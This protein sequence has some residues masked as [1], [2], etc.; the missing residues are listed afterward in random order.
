MV[1][2]LIG[3]GIAVDDDVYFLPFDSN[4]RARSTESLHL[5]QVLKELLRDSSN[6][7]GLIVLL[8]TCYAGIG[9]SE[10]ARW[11]EVGL[12]RHLRRYEIL[13]ASS[14]Q[15]AYNGNFTRTLI[16]VLTTGIRAAG[17]TIDA[18]YLRA[19]LM[20]RCGAQRPQ[21]VTHD[22]GGWAQAGDEGLW[23]A[24]N[25]AYLTGDSAISRAVIDRAAELTAYLEPTPIL[26]K[27]V[28]ASDSHQC[29]I[30]SGPRG[31]GKST[32]AAALSRP[33]ET[34]GM[35][36]AHFVQGVAFANRTSILTDIAATLAG[37]LEDSVPNFREAV[38]AYQRRLS[39][40]EAESLD[41]F[42]R[43]LVGP[44]QYLAPGTP[45]RI[46][47]DALDELPAATAEAMRAALN[48]ASALGLRVILTARPTVSGLPGS[49]RVSIESA[50]PD[51]MRSYFVKR[52][53]AA[54]HI[55][56]LVKRADGSW[57]HAYLMSDQALA[58]GFSLQDLPTGIRAPITALYE[59]ELVRGGAGDRK[60]WESDLRPVAGLLAVAGHGPQLPL[61]LATAASAKLGGPGTPTAFRDVLVRLSGLVVRDQPGQPTER[62]GFFHAS[63]ADD[64]F[65]SPDE[66]GQFPIDASLYHQALAD[67]IDQLAPLGS[68]DPA[69]SLHQYALMAEPDHRW[70]GQCDSGGVLASLAG[71]PVERAADQRERYQRWAGVLER[72]NGPEHL[73]TLAVKAD[74]ARWT[75]VAG[76]AVTARDTL[77]ELLP[78]RERVSGAH[79]PETLAVRADHARWTGLAGDPVGARELFARLLPVM[80]DVFGPDHPETLT[81]RANIARWTGLAGAVASARD[82]FSV[83]LPIRE[84]V[85]GKEHPETLTVRANT[86]RWTGLAGDP[87]AARDFFASLLPVRRRVSGPEHRHTLSDRAEFA[88]WTGEAGNAAAARDL[89]AE[90]L[91]AYER[92]NGPE[93]PHTLAVKADLARWTGV[94]DDDAVTARD[95]LSELLPARERMSGAH[96][97]ETLAVRA[98]H[99]RWTGLAGD[100]VGA[101]ELFARLLPVMEDV[102]G[103]D[104]PETLT[105]RANIARWT[106]LAGD[107]V[108]A[109]DFFASLLPVRRRVSGPEH[110]HT[111]SDRA[112]FA[113]WTGEA[114]NA[115]AARDLLAELLPAYER[116]NGPEHPHTLAVKADLARWTGVADDDAVTARDMLSELLPARERVSGAHHPETLAVRADHARWAVRVKPAES[117]RGKHSPSGEAG[118]D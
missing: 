15:P 89:L 17:T 75:G 92:A 53:V 96:H 81:V 74:L 50:K 24:R 39:R 44:L 29:V 99:A 71:R 85:S 54:A 31:S 51:V 86:A 108:A 68:H 30:V 87:V 115:A 103:P 7:D 19:P 116:A 110:R 98:D 49:C 37:Q 94:A 28:A 55:D 101:R 40:A 34:D 45:V 27:I 66:S 35:V 52:G 102:F 18:R 48:S 8:D 83:L 2:A 63:V 25:A 22:G 23:L 36:P 91:P 84:R 73:H 90:L 76:D 64:Y 33:T 65:L 97:P 13:T 112:E 5:S 106:G 80:E 109:R 14:A 12:G 62:V 3:H 107:P 6:L 105:V 1:L 46:V 4:G 114:G 118:E 104:H 41:A 111:L 79:H 93:H 69:R 38:F 57:L 100:P 60:V 56:E 16:E 88:R 113:R 47:I 95:M 9:A 26:E 20:E 42:H 10:A 117:T 67:A 58:P 32:I 78:A 59:N 77:S 43:M 72:A 82:L 61:A 21:R 11:Q 70:G